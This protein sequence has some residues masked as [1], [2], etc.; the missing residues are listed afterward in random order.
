[1]DDVEIDRGFLRVDG[2][3]IHYRS[4]GL[5]AAGSA[6]RPTLCMA[7]ASPGS[8]LGLVPLMQALGRDRAVIAPDMEGNGDSQAPGLQ[9]TSIDWYAERLARVLDRLGLDRV[10]LYGSHTGAQ[11]ALEFAL[12]FPDRVAGLVFDGIALFPDPVRQDFL[13]HYAPAMTP[14]DYGRHYAWAF[15]F[16]R[17]QFIHFP[18]YRRDA[19]HRRGGVT[20]IPSADRLHR[21][22]LEVLKSLQTYHLAY[23]AAFRHR[24]EDR[25][26]GLKIKP[27]LLAVEGDP[28]DVYADAA[29]ALLPAAEIWRGASA[30]K[31]APIRTFLET[32]SLGPS[33]A[34]HPQVAAGA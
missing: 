29:A 17:D 34:S 11:V 15:N 13:T 22:T 7:H 26:P 30:D 2:R 18:H 8:S 12:K 25:L 6:G 4:A 24:V 16:M 3:E 20:E 14:D 21:A 28:L 19:A 1:M 33:S 32:G 31:A 27:L 5:G 10:D 23:H 9:E